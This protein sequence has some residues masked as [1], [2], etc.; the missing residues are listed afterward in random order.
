MA[1]HFSVW[2][3]THHKINGIKVVFFWSTTVDAAVGAA[4]AGMSGSLPGNYL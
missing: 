4:V 2:L 3:Q 1:A